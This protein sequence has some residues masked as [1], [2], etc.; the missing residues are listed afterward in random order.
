MLRITGGDWGGRKIETLE[1]EATRPSMDQ[2]RQRLMNMLGHDLGG[3][4]VLDLFAGSGAFAFECLS[5]GAEKAVLVEQAKPALDVIRRNIAK[6]KPAAGAC[7]LLAASC[8]ALPPLA[9]AGKFDIVFV[10]PPYPHFV[11]E[12]PALDALV[13]SLPSLLAPD[14]IAIVQSDGGQFTLAPGTALTVD[15]VRSMGRTDFTFLRRA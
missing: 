9:D 4:R 6:L 11:S 8:Y 2:H 3:V 12:R 10:A 15:E 14:G 5:R 13:A 7:E 1:G